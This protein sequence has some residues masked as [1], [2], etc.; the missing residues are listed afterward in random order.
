MNGNWR[1]KLSAHRRDVR[2][3]LIIFAVT[4]VLFIFSPV[5]SLA[6]SKYSLIVSQSLLKHGSFAI[7]RFA[8]P[9]LDPKDNGAYVSNGNI[10]QQEWVGGR[11]YYYLPPGS[12]VLSLPYVALMNLFGVSVMNE[13]GTYNIDK[14]VKLQVGLAA[15]L[16]ATLAMVF[17]FT[18]RLVLPPGW[19]MLVAFGGTLGTQVWS[20]TSRVLWS[21]TW[22]I[23]ILGL[24]VWMLLAE[25]V[26]KTRLRPVLLASLLSWAYFVRPT[27]AIPI[28]GLTV[29]VL[30]FHRRLFIPYALT[31]FLWLALFIVYSW[32]HFGQ[33]L[34]NYYLASRLTFSHF[35]EA[36]GG[37]LISPSRGLLIYVPVLLAVFYLLARY[38]K[39]LVFRRLV[40]LSLS[41]I[42]AHWIITS[43]FPH[44]WGGYSY[45]P[46]LMAGV[47]PWLVLLGILGVQ[48][49]LRTRD[50]QGESEPHR[51]W[52]LRNLPGGL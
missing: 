28:F 3:G 9:R 30:I 18:T 25:A 14:E 22:G 36:L 13:D 24:V 34:P 42:V 11:L 27:N 23:F 51:I 33:L 2:L 16:M 37:N 20:T 52:R 31:G 38:R 8:L 44:W 7:D 1:Q 6:D 17:Y 35:G 41:I 12:S 32:A 29:Y 40:L 47:V 5:R 21:D 4:F 19:S 10:Y 46:R 26:G 45:G 43:G 39:K 49:M 48:A 15:I 50:G